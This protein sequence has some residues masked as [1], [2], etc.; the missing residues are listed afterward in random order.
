MLQVDLSNVWGE[1]ELND[2]LQAERRA[3]DAHQMLDGKEDGAMTGWRTLPA[4]YDREE[5]RRIRAAAEKINQESRVLVVIG[6]GGSYLGPRAVIELLRPENGVDGKHCQILFA[7][8]SLSTRAYNQMKAYLGDRDFSI[9]VVSKSGGTTEPAI[10]FRMFRRLLENKYGIEGSKS[11]IYVTAGPGKNA[12]RNL[13][14]SEG[15][16][17]FTIPDNIGGRYSVLTAVG[18]LPAAVAGINVSGLLAGAED[19]MKAFDVRTLDNPVWQYAAVRNLL[20]ERGKKIELLVSYEPSFRYM[21]Q[22]WQ[23]LFGESE[24]KDGKGIFPAGAEFTGDLH[25]LGQ[26]IQQGERHLFETVLQF[27]PDVQAATIEVDWQDSDGL[28]YLAGKTLDYVQRQ[29]FAGT[30][31]AHVDGGVPNIVISAGPIDEYAIGRLIYFFELVCGVS[32]YMLGVNPFDQPG[33]EAYKV[34]MFAMLGK[35]GY[36]KRRKELLGDTH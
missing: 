2:L 22:W 18:L 17:T 15:Y 11:R 25:S 29:A 14:V 4:D 1:L 6:I 34:N 33:V 21:C 16:Q 7:G 32:G 13:A 9:S 27:E 8:N 31:A 5:L 3:F 23:Q 30:L 36:E 19:G 10:A 20:Y 35:P 12:L 28:N 26:Y 24:G